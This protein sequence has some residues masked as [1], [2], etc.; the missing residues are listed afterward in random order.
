MFNTTKQFKT[1]RADAENTLAT[2]VKALENGKLKSALRMVGEATE[3]LDEQLDRITTDR[4][5][6]HVRGATCLG[7]NVRKSL[8]R[9]VE[10]YVARALEALREIEEVIGE[11][12]DPDEARDRL[13]M[14]DLHALLPEYE[15]RR[16]RRPRRA[17]VTP[18]AP[19]VTPSEAA[20]LEGTA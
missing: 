17:P 5:L 11:E 19:T 18:A 14:R 7:V 4:A 12:G 20:R 2:V 3:R 9:R 1:L 15:E 10:K 16:T 6:A 13:P 8:A